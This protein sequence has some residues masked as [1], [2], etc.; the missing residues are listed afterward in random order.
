MAV[1]THLTEA[2]IAAFL[3]RY[4]AG[5]LV[6]FKGIAEGV[7]NSNYL[8]VTSQAKYILTVYEKRVE[9]NDL[10]FFL[11][12]ME[13][14]AERGVPCPRP[15]HGRDGEMVQRVKDRPAALVTFLEGQGCRSIRN[16]HLSQ[17]GEHLARV[18]LAGDGFPLRRA[19]ALSL[20]GWRSL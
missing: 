3:A 6:S 4:D 2:E 19:N 7:E 15:L 16:A 20:R 1:Y 18:H 17:L 8:V 13:W 10:P 9:Q 11:G 14:L 12:M 5:T